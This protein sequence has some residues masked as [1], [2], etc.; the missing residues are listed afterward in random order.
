MSIVCICY[1][2]AKY[3]SSPQIKALNQEI[4]ANFQSALEAFK[5]KNFVVVHV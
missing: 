5:L 3:I 4:D 1:F 2:T